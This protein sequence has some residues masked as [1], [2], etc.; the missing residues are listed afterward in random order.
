MES[1]LIQNL[2]VSDSVNLGNVGNIT[3][4]GGAN[5]QVL[6]SWGNGAVYWGK[7]VENGA[8]ITTSFPGTLE[9]PYVGSAR[10]YIFDTVTISRMGAF[11]SQPA[12]VN[13][14]VK[15]FKNS[16]LAAVGTILAGNYYFGL[17]SV[18]G[19]NCEPGDYLTVN[20]DSGYPNNLSIVLYR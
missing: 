8:Y 19:F 2:S 12:T 9:T 13:V 15:V 5:S 7:S 17:S 20:V 1:L 3:I 16:V 10:R 4:T 18:A 11:V 14:V 6:T